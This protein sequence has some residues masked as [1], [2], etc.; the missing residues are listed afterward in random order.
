MRFPARRDLRRN[1]TCGNLSTLLGR[2]HPRC[3][4][5]TAMKVTPPLTHGRCC[6]CTIALFLLLAVVQ[7]ESFS[8]NHHFL[9]HRR[10]A[11]VAAKR[12]TQRPAPRRSN[13]DDDES[14][15]S[16]SSI[17]GASDALS[18]Q[19]QRRR[20]FLSSSLA[21]TSSLLLSAST[22]TAAEG[23]AFVES[24]ALVLG[25]DEIMLPK[26]HGT[27]DMPVRE[28]LRFGAS[29]REERSCTSYVRFYIMRHRID[30]RSRV[31]RAPSRM[32]YVATIACSPETGGYFDT[33]TSFE[34][35]VRR[36]HAS[37]RRRADDVLRLGIGPAVIPR[38][39]RPNGRRLRRREQ[40][41]RLAVV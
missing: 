41:P 20:A 35:D 17:V 1:H 9:D 23:Y 14:S 11:A 2:K 30:H 4:N 39:R 25:S 33:S 27:T 8:R 7:I 32:G 21:S 16:S 34:E 18:K 19:H 3:D 12:T 15:Y 13:S 24:D 28:N 29:T 40:G 5:I 31:S 22:P 37:V 10:A 38:P 6:R 36:Y 26:S